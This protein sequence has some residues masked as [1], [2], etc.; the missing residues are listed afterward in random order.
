[1]N[2]VEGETVEDLNFVLSRGG[3][4]TGR[5]TDSDGQPLIEQPV[6]FT[7]QD[8]QSLMVRS[9]AEIYTDDRGIYRAFGLRAGKYKVF[10]G[11]DGHRL[12]GPGRTASSGRTFYP[13][14][15]EE[16]KATEV[17]V[18]EGSEIKD[19]DIVM[20][21]RG[22]GGFKVSG[23]I[24]DGPTGKTLPNITYGVSQHHDGGTSS[25]S[26]ARSNADGEFK[27]D[28][29]LPGKYSVFIRPDP[30]LEIRANRVRFEVTDSDLTGIVV[31]TAK[32]ATLSGVVVIEGVDEK[33]VSKK[34]TELHISAHVSAPVANAEE[35]EM[36]DMQNAMP[37]LLKPDGSFRISGLRG[38]IANISV[39]SIGRSNSQEM[40]M[41]RVERDGVVQP[42]GISV[43][44]G[45]HV[46]GLRLVVR[47]LTGAI[48]GQIKIEGGELPP[49][50]HMFVSIALIGETPPR[51]YRSEQVDSR[52]RF[53]THA[54]AAGRYEVKLNAFG[55]GV[56]TNPN[57][58][59]QEVIVTDNTVSE[60]VLTLKLKNDP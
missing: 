3:V 32:A 44:E 50:T 4:I 49:S 45:E 7:V 48:R 16:A 25:T 59:K 58:S 22:P 19:I 2:I 15:T 31:K 40:T 14:T 38:G 34:L 33:S 41:V 54:L 11:S 12:P 10:A 20:A 57:E 21:S 52:G 36:H 39:V 51:S 26:G 17:E 37:M 9:Y 6:S 24:V 13:S 27:F 5:V 42:N 43:K 18:S 30:S 8:N 46:Q 23:R 47:Q 55:P 60:V 35:S 1:M 29:L 53:Y 28:S 56:L